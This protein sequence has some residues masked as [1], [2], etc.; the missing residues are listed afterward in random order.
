MWKPGQLITICGEVYRIKKYKVQLSRFYISLAYYSAGA[1]ICKKC[2]FHN[3]IKDECELRLYNP[4]YT[5]CGELI[6]YE[7]YFEK[8]WPKSHGEQDKL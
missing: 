4:K 7:C 8:V 5:S 3:H 2:P 6:P 1:L